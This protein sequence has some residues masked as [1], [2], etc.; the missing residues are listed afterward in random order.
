VI[1]LRLAIESR[2][3]SPLMRAV[4]SV[5]LALV[6]AGFLGSLAFALAGGEVSATWRALIKGALGSGYSLSE[7]LLKAAP[8]TLTG[9][10]VA[11]CRHLNLWNIGA[12]GQ[13]VFGALSACAVGLSMPPGWP[14]Y[15]GLPLALAAAIAGGAAYSLGPALLKARLGVSEILSTLLLNYVALLFMEHLYFGPWR[16]P[17]GMGF[18]GTAELPQAVWL[19]ALFGSRVHWGLP[20]ALG[21]SGAVWLLLAR[22]R[23]GFSARVLGLSPQAAAYAGFSSVSLTVTAMCLSGA[24]AGLAGAGELLG[25]QHRLQDGLASGLG[26]TGIIVAFL[27]RQNPLAVPLAALFLGGLLVGADQLQTEL[28]LPGAVIA[29]LQAALL[30]GFMLGEFLAGKRLRLKI[31]ASGNDH[32]S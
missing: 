29:T 25:V 15:L 27:A 31:S 24:L 7:I 11:L 21:L 12:E 13:F 22:T 1:S 6:A 10:A 4:L 30:F 20:L 23:W 26:F 28:R 8:L 32:A 18:P 14:A 17:L 2:D 9:L 16:D 5:L 19:P 3:S